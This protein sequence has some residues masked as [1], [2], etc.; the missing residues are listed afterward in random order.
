M[1]EDGVAPDDARDLWR[2]R[3][4]GSGLVLRPRV[5]DRL[6]DPAVHVA[7]IIAPGGYGKTSHAAAFVASDPRP[8]AWIDIE[9]GLDDAPALLLE[10]LA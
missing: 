5:L 9:P 4:S 8:T 6:S 7:L 1:S 3:H 10:L 2:G